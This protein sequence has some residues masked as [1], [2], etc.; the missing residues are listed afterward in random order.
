MPGTED[1]AK[2]VTWAVHKVLTVEVSGV[3]ETKE[4]TGAR[5]KA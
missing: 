2:H 1:R 4:G 5:E 3:Q